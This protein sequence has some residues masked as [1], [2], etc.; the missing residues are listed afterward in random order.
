MNGL[1]VSLFCAAG[2]LLFLAISA[3]ILR[4]IVRVRILN[5]FGVD[6]YFMVAAAA[7]TSS[8]FRNTRG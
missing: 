3:T 1:D 7:S 8:F 6:D 4:C 5:A 2:L